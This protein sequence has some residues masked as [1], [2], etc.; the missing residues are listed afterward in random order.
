MD[1]RLQTHKSQRPSTPTQTPDVS[2]LKTFAVLCSRQTRRGQFLKVSQ[3]PE[4][5]RSHAIGLSIGRLILFFLL[6]NIPEYK[7]PQLLSQ[8]SLSGSGGVSV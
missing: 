1:G 6:H 5:A 4:R 2:T 3:T 8:L 7:F